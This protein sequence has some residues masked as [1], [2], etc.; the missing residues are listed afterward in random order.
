MTLLHLYLSPEHNYFG[1]HGQPAGKA[2]MIEVPELKLVAG[3][4]IEGDRFFGFKKD[5]KGQVTFFEEEIYQ[6]LCRPFI[7]GPKPP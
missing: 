2:P 1:H 7:L 4:G 5:Y 6:S 3:Q